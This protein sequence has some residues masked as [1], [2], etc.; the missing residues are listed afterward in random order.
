MAPERR[1]QIVLAVVTVILLIVAYLALDPTSGAP[2]PSSNQNVTASR[3]A[4]AAPPQVSAPEVHLEALNAE[5]PKPTGSERNLFRFKQ[6]APPPAPPPQVTKPVDVAPPVP[7]GPPPP[8]PL[9]PI[10]LK[11]IGTM[12]RNG[13][14]MAAL[15]DGAGNVD[16]AVEG[17]IIGGRFRVLK[18]GEQSIEMA[19]L[20][21][22]GRQTIRLTGS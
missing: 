14:R 11:F 21:G 18:I 22:R 3:T 19:Y 6:K 20:D 12:V 10:T 15:S 9:P 5:R 4:R 2:S 8:P 16:Y 7:M 17:G 1:N 13:Q